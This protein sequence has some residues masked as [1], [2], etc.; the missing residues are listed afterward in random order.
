[1]RV[2]IVLSFLLFLFLFSCGSSKKITDPGKDS[3]PLSFNIKKSYS[4]GE[5]INIEM[6]NQ[7]ET[8]S[9]YIH[10]PAII[11]IEK[12]EGNEWKKM[13]IRYCPCGASCPPPPE[14]KLLAPGKIYY[15]NWDQEEEWCGKITGKGIPETHKE[16]AGSGLYRIKVRYKETNNHTIHTKT[17]QF[18]IQN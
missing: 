5:E 18:R 13:R 16:M 8:D 7:S 2:K 3:T 11:H 14:E 9:F 17:K 4:V 12:K 1:M 10:Q 15:I 6:I